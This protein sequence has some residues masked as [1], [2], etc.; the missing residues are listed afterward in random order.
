M[1]ADDEQRIHKLESDVAHLEHQY[2]ELNKIVVRQ[3]KQI[4]RLQAV[5]ERVDNTMR[6]QEMNQ[7][8]DHNTKPPHYGNSA[9]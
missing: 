8:R 2:D 9:L 6:D 4:A 1:A 7:T 3:E 5:V